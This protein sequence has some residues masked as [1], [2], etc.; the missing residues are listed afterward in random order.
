M[1]VKWN[2]LI[3]VKKHIIEK[4]LSLKFKPEIQFPRR[5]TCTIEICFIKIL[6]LNRKSIYLISTFHTFFRR[7]LLVHWNKPIWEYCF[8]VEWVFTLISY[9]SN[10]DLKTRHSPK[11]TYK[12]IFTICIAIWQSCIKE[13]NIF[14]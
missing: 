4:I 5:K 2:A 3:A 13:S 9:S 10:K 8:T 12:I 14:N 11:F 1:T 6:T 7:N